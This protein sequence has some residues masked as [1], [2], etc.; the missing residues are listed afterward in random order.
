MI[1]PMMRRK[2]GGTDGWSWEVSS[3][4]LTEFVT[5]TSEDTGLAARFA[6]GWASW[7]WGIGLGLSASAGGAAEEKP[8]ETPSPAG[9][10]GILGEAGRRLTAHDS[11][12]E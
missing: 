3:P 8:R 5:V 6:F 7:Y 9:N 11:P 12:I 1:A 10:L 2:F 4:E